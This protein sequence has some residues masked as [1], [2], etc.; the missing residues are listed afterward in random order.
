MSIK[1]V[2][3]ERLPGFNAEASLSPSQERYY[4]IRDVFFPALPSVTSA[5]NDCPGCRRFC[6]PC[7]NCLKTSHNPGRCSSVCNTCWACDCFRPPVD[8]KQ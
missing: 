6:Y 7:Y 2:N 5:F 4:L 1:E 3:K 8:F